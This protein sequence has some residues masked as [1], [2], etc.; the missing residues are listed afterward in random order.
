MKSKY[1]YYGNLLQGVYD[2]MN[3]IGGT[4]YDKMLDTGCFGIDGT[5][6]V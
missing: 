6:E 2:V 3:A 5:L 4:G 1:L